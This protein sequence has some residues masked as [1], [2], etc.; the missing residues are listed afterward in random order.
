MKL[1]GQPFYLSDPQKGVATALSSSLVELVIQ[2]SA[3]PQL[4]VFWF[5]A[6]KHQGCCFV[7]HHVVETMHQFTPSEVWNPHHCLI[8]AWSCL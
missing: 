8:D 6:N 4:L 2:V 1:G 5:H 7:Q 3:A